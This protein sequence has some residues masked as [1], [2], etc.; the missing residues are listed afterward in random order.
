MCLRACVCA[1]V[2]RLRRR[3]KEAAG[4]E[5]HARKNDARPANKSCRATDK[6]GLA[7][8]P[9]NYLRPVV[10]IRNKLFYNSSRGFI[11]LPKPE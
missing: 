11:E 8:P 7:G 10:S 9:T 6:S 1:C 5:W 3:D 4:S 2:L